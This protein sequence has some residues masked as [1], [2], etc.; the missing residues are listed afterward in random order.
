MHDDNMT[1]ADLHARRRGEPSLPQH[2]ASAQTSERSELATPSS[3]PFRSYATQRKGPFV[4]IKGGEE[5]HAGTLS[6][7][8]SRGAVAVCEVTAANAGKGRTVKA[9]GAR[10]RE[11]CWFA[12]RLRVS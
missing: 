4:C 9:E 11:E 6:L 2:F 8:E 5:L 7:S 3:P 10:R 12:A 1:T